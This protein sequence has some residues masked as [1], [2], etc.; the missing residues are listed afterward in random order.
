M[1]Q[2]KKS[3]RNP[4]DQ[5]PTMENSRDQSPIEINFNKACYGRPDHSDDSDVGTGIGFEDLLIANL[6]TCTE[7]GTLNRQ[8]TP[9]EKIKVPLY[10]APLATVEH[11]DAVVT[12]LIPMP[13][14]SDDLVKALSICLFKISL[15]P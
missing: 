11:P 12:A 4:H 10:E 1:P 13:D 2:E 3:K 6:D 15:H 5:S 8:D 9:M 7:Q 14:T